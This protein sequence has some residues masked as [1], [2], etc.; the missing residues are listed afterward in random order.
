MTAYRAIPIASS[1]R[2]F[3]VHA[4]TEASV[5][6][7]VAAAMLSDSCLSMRRP[8]QAFI[9]EQ[10]VYKELWTSTRAVTFCFTTYK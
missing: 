3:A 9:A 10:V 4:S 7:L 6:R 1:D 8:V 5:C 2:Q